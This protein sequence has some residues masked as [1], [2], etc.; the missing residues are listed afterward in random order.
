[1]GLFDRDKNSIYYNKGT[2]AKDW[3]S[4]GSNWKDALTGIYGG[5]SG[6]DG[7]YYTRS[8]WL[9]DGL[10]DTGVGYMANSN[11]D[12]LSR[13]AHQLAGLNGYNRNK[14]LGINS[15]YNDIENY[16]N[17]ADMTNKYFNNVYNKTLSDNIYDYVYNNT[18]PNYGVTV[19]D[20]LNLDN[21][22]NGLSI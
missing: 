14:K 19:G 18:Y 22:G 17:E 15:K 11:Q 21:Y 10:A 1:M 3:L 5:L 13:I 2:M 12:Y 8:R 20:Y 16:I 7:N 6:G 4:S 9:G